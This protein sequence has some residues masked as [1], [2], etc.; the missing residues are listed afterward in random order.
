MQCVSKYW[1]F[2]L[3]NIIANISTRYF[4]HSAT[5]DTF[6]FFDFKTYWYLRH[7]VCYENAFGILLLMIAFLRLWFACCL[8]LLQ[9]WFTLR[10]K[11][12]F[13]VLILHEIF[14]QDWTQSRT[15]KVKESSLVCSWIAIGYRL[16]IVRSVK[17]SAVHMYLNCKELQKNI[18]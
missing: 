9:L 3:A 11:F 14:M 13:H 2:L 7:Q 17:Q 4:Y 1:K 12:A 8:F 18:E 16:V 5:S 10:L 15:K 6:F